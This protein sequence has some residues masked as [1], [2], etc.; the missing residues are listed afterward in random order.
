MTGLEPAASRLEVDN[1][2]PAARCRA[3][4][5]KGLAEASA[6][7]L[8]YTVQIVQVGKDRAGRPLLQA[9]L[10][11]LAGA[12][13]PVGHC[14]FRYRYRPG[15]ESRTRWNQIT[16]SLW[17]TCVNTILAARLIVWDTVTF[18]Q[19]PASG[20][21]TARERR[22]A[23]IMLFNWEWWRDLNPHGI[24]ATGSR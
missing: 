10:R 23:A 11:I 12:D 2:L 16:Q 8:S 21:S 6:L 9:L 14:G 5:G 24:A 1:P 20:R 15:Y 7:P 4:Y 13:N 3:N 19:R 17:P 18:H 22:I